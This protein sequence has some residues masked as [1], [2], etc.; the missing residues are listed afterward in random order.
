VTQELNAYD[1]L[2]SDWVVFT[3]DSLP[4]PRPSKAEKAAAAAAAAAEDKEAS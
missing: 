4:Q 2:V 1:V 3:E